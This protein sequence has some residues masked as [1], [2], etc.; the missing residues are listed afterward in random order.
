MFISEHIDIQLREKSY[1]LHSLIK[2]SLMELL[3]YSTRYK[4]EKCRTIQLIRNHI[5]RSRNTVLIRNNLNNLFPCG[6]WGVSDM[7]M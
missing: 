6:G 3:T 7:A 1:L 5:V 2:L 4:N